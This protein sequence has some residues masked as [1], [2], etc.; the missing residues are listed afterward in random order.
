MLTDYSVHYFEYGLH[1]MP[2][3]IQY[4]RLHRMRGVMTGGVLPGGV[5]IGG[6]D[7]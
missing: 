3:L 2:F 6:N 7:V 4:D 5:V 1:G